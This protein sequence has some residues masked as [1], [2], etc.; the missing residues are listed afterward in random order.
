MW[1]PSKCIH[2]VYEMGI[3]SNM[4]Y[5]A[6]YVKTEEWKAFHLPR[7][8]ELF[9]VTLEQSGLCLVSSVFTQCKNSMIA[10]LES[11]IIVKQTL[12]LPIPVMW[13]LWVRLFVPIFM[14]RPLI[15]PLYGSV[16]PVLLSARL[17]PLP[18]RAAPTSPVFLSYCLNSIINPTTFKNTF[19]WNNMCLRIT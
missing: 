14:L 10:G 16:V 8:L 19:T 4:I 15:E 5:G 2:I 13:P 1:Q 11:V 7:T 12:M 6:F 17:Q 18:H 9:I 3:C